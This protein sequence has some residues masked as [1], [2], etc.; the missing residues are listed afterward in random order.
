MLC[1]IKCIHT[2]DLH[3]GSQF[4]TV[5]FNNNFG[6]QRRLELMDTFER[7]INRAKDKNVDFLLLAGDMC[8]GEYFNIEICYLRLITL[9]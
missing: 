6:R 5:S 7:I 1:L 3:L 2:G 8:E 4:K 9:I